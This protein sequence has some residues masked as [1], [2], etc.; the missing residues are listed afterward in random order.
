MKSACTIITGG[1]RFDHCL[2]VDEFKQG[3]NCEPDRMTFMEPGISRPSP[4]R[5]NVFALGNSGL[6]PFLFAEVG[7]ESNG[8]PLSVLSVLARL[9][10][11]PWVTAA[12]WVTLPKT[13]T[14]DRLTECIAQ[15]P[16]S[17]RAL[18]EASATAARLV[19]LLPSRTETATDPASIAWEM[20]RWVPLAIFC[21][22][23]ASV[24]AA[25]LF[26]VP[27]PHAA[28]AAPSVQTQGATTPR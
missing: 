23:V 2:F 6:G 25:G 3:Q 20:P 11:D 27:N 28:V 19:L 15:M 5:A 18:E 4:V 26:P 14:I 13:L 16:L 8:S 17:P 21:C 24:L 1:L 22:F 12:Q 10:Q 9:G 7:V